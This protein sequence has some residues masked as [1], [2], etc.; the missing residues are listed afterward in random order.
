MPL[1]FAL[2]DLTHR[3]SH[4]PWGMLFLFCASS[5][6]KKTCFLL[7]FFALLPRYH[8]WEYFLFYLPC[9]R[10][11]ILFPFCFFVLPFLSAE[12]PFPNL[13]P[14]SIG[15]QSSNMPPTPLAFAKLCPQVLFRVSSRPPALVLEPREFFPLIFSPTRGA[16][17]PYNN[18]IFPKRRTS[19]LMLK[20]PSPFCSPPPVVDCSP[21]YPLPIF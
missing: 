10:S 6:L 8:V 20:L 1:S 4:W 14:R 3:V 19:F 9:N 16:L 13:T 5:S 21:K 15:A 18:P 7:L 2:H 12:R 11:E 17:S